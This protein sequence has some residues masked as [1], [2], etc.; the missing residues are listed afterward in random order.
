MDEI[1]AL[2]P[3]VGTLV[4]LPKQQQQQQHLRE[5]QAEFD[6]FC[7]SLSLL[8][9]DKVDGKVSLVASSSEPLTV[10]A[11][12]TIISIFDLLLK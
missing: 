5:Q 11:D 10:G 6:F 9:V 8:P 3:V 4:V 12:S 2:L 1:S 7:L